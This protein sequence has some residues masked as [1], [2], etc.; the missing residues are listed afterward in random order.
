M[1]A[2][3]FGPEA[4]AGPR[5]IQPLFRFNRERTIAIAIP[6]D[7]ALHSGALDIAVA[8]LIGLVGPP[9]AYGRLASQFDPAAR[10]DPAVRACAAADADGR[11][12]GRGYANGS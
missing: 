1:E 12:L 3:I 7:V 5:A 9:A 6:D 8:G 11:E 4:S 2:G 10:A